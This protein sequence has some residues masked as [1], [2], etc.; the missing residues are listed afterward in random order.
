MTCRLS[1][2]GQDFMENLGALP[3]L[4][5]VQDENFDLN[6]LSFLRYVLN[7]TKFSAKY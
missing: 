5:S 4:C 7:S 1:K 3:Y 2:D 6:F